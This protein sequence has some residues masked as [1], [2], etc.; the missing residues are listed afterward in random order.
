MSLS[1]HRVEYSDTCSQDTF[2]VKIFQYIYTSTIKHSFI[3]LSKRVTFLKYWQVVD[4]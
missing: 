2:F 4:S 3:I 1:R